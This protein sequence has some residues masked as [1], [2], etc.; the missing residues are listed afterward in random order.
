[1]EWSPSVFEELSHITS[2]FWSRDKASPGI[3]LFF[4]STDV[5]ARSSAAMHMVA[6][7]LFQT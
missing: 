4:G 3:S 5:I 6:P 7:L 2:P 1:M